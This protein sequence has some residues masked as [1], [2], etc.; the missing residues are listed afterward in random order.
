[1]PGGK[2]SSNNSSYC[3]HV[4]PL[5]I[6]SE[7]RHLGIADACHECASKWQGIHST[8]RPYYRLLPLGIVSQC[9]LDERSGLLE[10]IL[11]LGAHGSGL[12]VQDGKS[13]QCM[14]TDKQIFPRNVVHDKSIGRAEAQIGEHY[15]EGK[16][17]DWPLGSLFGSL[18]PDGKFSPNLVGCPDCDIMAQVRLSILYHCAPRLT[19]RS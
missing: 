8:S 13:K 9:E 11:G 3:S 10:G 17:Y 15:P 6:R 12:V 19:Y 4:D 7:A 2:S 5:Q 1:M 18:F 16:E 14:N